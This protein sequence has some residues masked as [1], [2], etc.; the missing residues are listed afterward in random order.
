LGARPTPAN[1]RRLIR[2]ENIGNFVVV[3]DAHPGVTNFY[4]CGK[5]K[6]SVIFGPRVRFMTHIFRESRFFIT[7]KQAKLT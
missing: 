5:L 1:A 4:L 6:N 2:L 7:K 3:G